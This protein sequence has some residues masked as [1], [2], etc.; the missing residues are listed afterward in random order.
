MK[1]IRYY[2]L[3]TPIL[4][5]ISMPVGLYLYGLQFIE[6]HLS[7]PKVPIANDIAASYKNWLGE[8][9]ESNYRKLNPYTSLFVVFSKYYL[10]DNNNPRSS[11]AD[12]RLYL[13]AT[14]KRMQF[15]RNVKGMGIWH[16]ARYSAQ[17]YISRHWTVDQSVTEVLQSSYYGREQYGLE[18]ASMLYFGTRATELNE[19][20]LYALFHL[21]RL[22]ARYDL[23]CYP[24]RHRDSSSKLLKQRGVKQPVADVQ[25]LPAPDNAC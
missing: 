11:S 22:P 3:I 6:H 9:D 1:S 2:L 19:S 4:I 23:W 17:I 24:E 20:Q 18:N 13:L 21:S 10:N 25:L 8:A 14:Q 16:T 5:F 12:M 7:A 15:I